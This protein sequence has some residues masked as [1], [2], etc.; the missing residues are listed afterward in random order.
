[1]LAENRFRAARDGMR[2][3]FIGGPGGRRVASDVLADRLEICGPYA[4]AL[5]C[6]EELASV[7]A[8]PAIPA[9]RASGGSPRAR[10]AMGWSPG[11]SRTSF[12]PAARSPPDVV[13]RRAG[14]PG[15]LSGAAA[16]AAGR[17]R[18]AGR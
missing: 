4:A 8:L 17:A 11:S 10:A 9:T 18:V 7:A 14:R 2:A 3:V 13:G 16:D 6:R 1:V 15:S 5:G 12:P